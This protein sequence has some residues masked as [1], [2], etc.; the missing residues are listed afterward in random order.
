MFDELRDSLRAFSGRL[1]PDERRRMSTGMREALVHAKLGLQDLR[2]GLAQTET[3]LSAEQKELDTVRRR[4]ALAAQV[5]DQETV[6]IAER[7]ASQ[8]AERVAM[9]ESKRMVQ[10]QELTLAEREY[11]AMSAELRRVMSGLAPEASS[12]DA[13]AA[14]EVDALLSDD[15]D[16]GLDLRDVPPPSRRSRADREADA[17]ARLADLKRRFGK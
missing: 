12:P 17:D 10:Q 5:D 8:H 3:R 9:L 4:Q 7:F 6:A 16:A 1:D 13:A 15:P 11:E 14:R 2:N